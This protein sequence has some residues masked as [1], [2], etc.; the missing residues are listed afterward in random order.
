MR[1]EEATDTTD[2]VL[3]TGEDRTSL[4]THPACLNKEAFDGRIVDQVSRH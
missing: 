4:V 1:E 2:L 3:L